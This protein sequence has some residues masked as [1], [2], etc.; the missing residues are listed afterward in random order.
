MS[1][2]TPA[3][4]PAHASGT[5]A[6]TA[7]P[8]SDYDQFV[9]WGKRLA[10]EAPLFRR[11]FDEV[12]ATTAIDVGAGSARHSIMFAT[13]GMAVDAVDPSDSMLAQAE[14]NV[15]RATAEI[16]AAGGQLRV[17]KAGFGELAARGLG[18]VDAVICT[19]NALPHVEG[20]DGLRSA[21]ADFSEVLRP[22]GALVLHLLNHQRLLDGRP[23]A[24]PP[25]V[26][27]TDEG[28]KIFLRVIGYPE[29]EEYI[30]FDFLTLVR[31]ADGR[32]DLASRR[33]PHTAL[34]ASLLAE[35]LEAHGFGRIELLGGHDGHALS[36]ADESVIV[37]ARRV[38][39][40]AEE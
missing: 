36:D 19:G 8:A 24:I 30:D 2:E 27:E 17:T 13:W 16:E 32:W 23:R 9:D 21:L 15:A 4:T 1:A 25:V 5:A 40:A 33:S 12:G 31:G 6:S 7:A 39:V 3:P 28:T 26:R 10:R 37:V 35:E 20:H 18:P 11:V 14:E 34:P 38:G 22:G 29:G